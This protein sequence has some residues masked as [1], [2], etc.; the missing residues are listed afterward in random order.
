[1]HLIAA[2]IDRALHL[3][4]RAREALRTYAASCPGWYIKD[5]H[6]APVHREGALGVGSA[7]VW[8][9][10]AAEAIAL[11]AIREKHAGSAQPAE[12]S[13]A[14]DMCSL[15]MFSPAGVSCGVRWMVGGSRA[16]SRVSGEGETPRLAA[17]NFLAAYLSGE[18]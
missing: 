10:A 3:S 9:P 14:I 11:A 5:T 12:W 2:E 6:T 15:P 7:G 4:E 16:K 8:L 1:M 13:A 17:L 18:P